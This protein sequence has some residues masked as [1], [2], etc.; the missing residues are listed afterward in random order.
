MEEIFGKNS[1][2]ETI[3]SKRKIYKAFIVKENNKKIEEIISLLTKENVEIE[4]V[5]KSYFKNIKE[6]HQ[7]VKLLAEDFK[8]TDFDELLNEDFLVIL[9]HI[10]DVHNLGAIIRTCEVMGVCGVIIPDR[11]AAKIN[12]S[13]Y[14][15]SSGAVNYIKVSKVVN[16]NNSIKELKKNG[17]WVYGLAGEAEKYIYDIDLKG[18]VA[19]VVGNE[20]KGISKLTRNFCDDLLKIP[21]QGKTTSLNASVAASIAIYEVKRQNGKN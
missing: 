4:F 13:V 16:I 15:T 17:F 2:I 5:E 12:S 6:N 20:E 10:E 18:K 3:N 1:A 8:Y 21:M 7:G 19:I 11:R 14:K 9:D